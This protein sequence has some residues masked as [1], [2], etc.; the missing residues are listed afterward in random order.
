MKKV[1]KLICVFLS[2]FLLV[3]C[4]PK[5]EKSEFIGMYEKEFNRNDL[6]SWEIKDGL[7]YDFE[8][9]KNLLQTL[10]VE[11][12]EGEVLHNTDER[13]VTSGDSSM[14]SIIKN[15]A[16][17]NSTTVKYKFSTGK[18][19]KDITRLSKITMDVFNVNPYKVKIK[20]ILISTYATYFF[21]EIELGANEKSLVEITL[22][23]AIK[24]YLGEMTGFELKNLLQIEYRLIIPQGATGEKIFYFDSIKYYS[25]DS[26]YIPIPPPEQISRQLGEVNNFNDANR[27]RFVTP[28]YEIGLAGYD[29]QNQFLTTSYSSDFKKEG[30]GSLK[31]EIEGLDLGG[32][33]AGI[34]GYPALS[35]RRAEQI[36]ATNLAKYNTLSFWVYYDAK[37]GSGGLAKNP[38]TIK[39]VFE[40]RN[41]YYPNSAEIVSDLVIPKHKWVNIK[42]N[43]GD[44]AFGLRDYTTALRFWTYG[45]DKTQVSRTVYFDDI[46]LSTN[47]MSAAE[48]GGKKYSMVVEN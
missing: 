33:D 7:L 44:N 18:N 30:S 26:G 29:N 4:A 20:P 13:F 6:V 31:F 45:F 48:L 32:F 23:K 12:F 3:S 10:E 8:Q 1:S 14:K 16:I 40:H 41:N 38:D 39:F 17:K 19:G 35:L 43:L 24:D 22:N 2:M 28:E 25:D 21:D 47:Q 37:R 34:Y 27:C 42:I 36:G 11:N 9:S 15:S 46:T 5:A